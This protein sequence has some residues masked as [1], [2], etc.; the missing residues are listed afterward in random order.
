M[1]PSATSVIFP[2]MVSLVILPEETSLT[3]GCSLHP[4]S[5]AVNSQQNCR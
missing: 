2:A 1:E 5:G 3:A 4:A